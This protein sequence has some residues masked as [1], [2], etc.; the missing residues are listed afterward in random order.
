MK[1]LEVDDGPAKSCYAGETWRSVVRFGFLFPFC[2]RMQKQKVS[3]FHRH[4][5]YVSKLNGGHV[6]EP[7][8]L[9][10]R[11]EEETCHGWF[12]SGE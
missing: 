3:S 7:Y 5:G 11:T 6:D 1:K 9:P 12:M 8:E 4:G 10:T 2:S